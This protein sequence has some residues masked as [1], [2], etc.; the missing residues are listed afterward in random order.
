MK[1]P[2]HFAARG[3]C[4]ACALWLCAPATL[5]QAPRDSDGDGIADALDP[6]PL[7]SNL[8][9][10]FVYRL[11]SPTL[12]WELDQEQFTLVEESSEQVEVQ[13]ESARQAALEVLSETTGESRLRVIDRVPPEPG[14]M[15]LSINPLAMLGGLVSGSGP[16]DA[17]ASGVRLGGGERRD[18]STD[19]RETSIQRRIQREESRSREQLAERRSRLLQ[20][21]RYTRILRNPKLQ[22][23]LHVRNGGDG[24]LVIERPEVPVLAGARMLGVAVPLD[25]RDRDSVVIPRGRSQAILLAVPVGDTDFWDALTRGSDQ[26]VYEP[27]LGAMRAHFADAPQTDLLALGR[28][29]AVASL[30][31]RILL[32]EGA[33][34]EQSLARRDAQGAPVT[35]RAALQ[36]WN[37]AWRRQQPAAEGDLIRLDSAGQVVAAAGRTGS[38]LGAGWQLVVDGRTL[39]PGESTDVAVERSLELRWG[40]LHSSLDGLALREP[41]AGEPEVESPWLRAGLVAYREYGRL[42]AGVPAGEV[43]GA[44]Q[45]QLDGPLGQLVAEEY[46]GPLFTTLAEA[47][48]LAGD[49]ESARANWER[50]A[51]YG[52]PQ[53]ILA[54]ANQVLELPG[55]VLEGVQR[56]RQAAA[57]GSSEALTRLAEVEQRSG[58]D[59]RRALLLI[60]QAAEAG[61]APALTTLGQLYESGDGLPRDTAQAA[62]LYREAASRGDVAAM[63]RLGMLHETGQGVP[64]DPARASAWYRAAASGE[65]WTEEL[66]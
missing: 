13:L 15:Q 36:A 25:P 48:R 19:T 32:P 60:G 55:R 58:G 16:L 17:L 64:R 52:D 54:L 10:R 28:E 40:D 34:M 42:R 41:A 18:S 5:A 57:A 59:R 44:L 27:L 47:Q 30:P 23:S 12:T 33:T 11:E 50:A 39:A 62:A 7:L 53:A 6:E 24:P 14:W 8:S 45:A 38:A 51:K 63:L 29:S 35:A 2:F 65:P 4:A 43:I 26:I 1:S 20:I 49:I 22:I 31:A 46:R 3:L 37:Q 9:E 21:Q 66:P 56:L 61:Y